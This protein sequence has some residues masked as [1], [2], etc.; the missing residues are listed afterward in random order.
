[1]VLLHLLS[2]QAES[3]PNYT[4]GSLFRISWEAY[5]LGYTDRRILLE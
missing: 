3:V 2:M 1:M 4:P 5:I